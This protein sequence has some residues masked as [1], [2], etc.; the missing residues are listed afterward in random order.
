MVVVPLDVSVALVVAITV[1]N[2]V[3]VLNVV[4]VAYAVSNVV[5][6]LNVVVVA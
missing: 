3:V 5:V 6:V 2:V 1:S 4:V